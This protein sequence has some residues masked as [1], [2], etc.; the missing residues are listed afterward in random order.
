MPTLHLP[1]LVISPS[2]R[3]VG[4]ACLDRR[5]RPAY[6]G[7]VFLRH[8]GEADDRSSLLEERLA[9]LIREFHVATIV[10]EADPPGAS[11][12]R[13]ILVALVRRALD[14]A[15]I[16]I[17]ARSFV[18]ASRRISDGSRSGVV[19][20]LSRRFPEAATRF[21]SVPLRIVSS[22]AW[23]EY[24]PKVVAMTIALAVGLDLFVG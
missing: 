21:G 3:R 7:S 14:R 9:W 15:A 1:I 8:R 6:V 16:P 23:K 10:V 5:L 20:A 13:E 4:I 12:Q 24:R 17:V 2:P 18:V 22:P 11:P 19:G